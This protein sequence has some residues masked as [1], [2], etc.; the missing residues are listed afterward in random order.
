MQHSDCKAPYRFLT[1]S[2]LWALMAVNAAGFTQ[3]A[4]VSGRVLGADGKPVEHATVLVYE[5]RVRRGYSVYCPTCWIDCGKR[6]LTKPDGEYSISG[7]NPDLIFKLLVVRNGYKPV[8]IEKVD[9]LK[10]PANDA[11][12]KATVA[13]A[14][15]SQ[16]VRGR[17]LDNQG[18]PVRD[19]VVQQ[20]G[21]TF[22]GGG[23]LF[24]PDD[25]PDWIQPLAATDEQGK[26]EITY[27]KPLAAITLN[28]SPRAMAPKLVTL[29]TGPGEKT[30]TVAEGATLRGRLLEPDGTPARNAE[31]GVFVHSRMAGAVFQE[32]RI[33]TKDDG[34]FAITNLP[35]G[36]IW[37]V[38]PRMESLAARGLVGD[39][40]LAETK[41]N[42]EEVN[43]GTIKLRTAY[44]LRG[45]VVLSDGN[46]IPPDMHVT[47]SSDAG[48][49][50][51]I[52]TITQDGS[53][54]F[55]G[56]SSGV[57]SIAPAVRGYKATPDFTGEVLI[58]RDGKNIVIP[59]SPLAPH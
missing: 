24:G 19:A 7:L 10:G 36:R 38:Y 34:T 32:V 54:E 9:P 42:G 30:V 5:A 25:S 31:I 23:R 40:V 6:T 14:E 46:Q 44:T 56:L 3:G 53:F 16:T 55:R 27:A 26:F 21:I 41:D 43:V 8:F 20:Q 58:D 12:L 51:Q 48:F 57:Y 17:V 59:L 18:T 11:S 29:P 28:V 2:V 35:A 45:K 52:G 4:T 33:G 49:D 1:V 13:A 47:L 22:S 50:S 37:Y 39:A 15:P